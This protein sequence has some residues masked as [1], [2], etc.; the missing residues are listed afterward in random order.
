M[1]LLV[2]SRPVNY[3]AAVPCWWPLCSTGAASVQSSRPR[4]QGCSVWV[5]QTSEQSGKEMKTAVK[6]NVRLFKDNVDY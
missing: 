6:V 1:L 5:I 2:S 4:D 3:R